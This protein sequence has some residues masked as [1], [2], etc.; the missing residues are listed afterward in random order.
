MASQETTVCGPI[1]GNSDLY[2]LGIRVGVYLQWFSSWF[3]LLVEP[4]SAQEIH[5]VNSVFVFAIIIATTLAARAHI[6]LPVEAY[7]ML[8]FGFG[9]FFTTMSIIGVRLQLM[10]P[11]RMAELLDA[12]AKVPERLR[13]SF[14]GQPFFERRGS[15]EKQ[16]KVRG[17]FATRFLKLAGF[18][19]VYSLNVPMAAISF[20]KPAVLSWSGVLWRTVIAGMVSGF[21]LWFWYYGLDY[22]T[23]GQPCVTEVFLFAQL[24]LQGHLIG[25]FKALG[26]IFGFP[27]FFLCI[28]LGFIAIRLAIFFAV[29]VY[30]E[31]IFRTAESIEPGFVEKFQGTLKAIEPI[32]QPLEVV[33]QV[34]TFGM[35]NV[36]PW[37]SPEFWATP[38]AKIPRFTDLM[39]VFAA[40][41]GGGITSD[42]KEADLVGTVKVRYDAFAAACWGIVL[43]VVAD[44]SR[45]M[46]HKVLCGVWHAGIICAMIWFVLSVE[47]TLR[48]NDVQ[49]V[50][51]IESTG[52]LIPFIIGVVSS[53]QAVKKVAISTIKKVNP[54]RRAA[55]YY[56]ILTFSISSYIRTGQIQN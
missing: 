4:A 55:L 32:M 6:L 21:N 10:S 54:H 11:A 16:K 53:A 18:L 12:L 25:F 2:G 22:L 43:G 36:L 14:I 47:L 3:S 56:H 8:Q 5:E 31:F 52:Q 7:I 48:W 41:A 33:T 15:A 9:Y 49:G 1:D 45:R 29:C 35:V 40:L 23:P 19:H 24:P 39:K 13:E 34:G 44:T 46:I 38:L 17:S 20:L 50:N 28:Y 42:L 27:A 30:R 51:T 37:V 26:I